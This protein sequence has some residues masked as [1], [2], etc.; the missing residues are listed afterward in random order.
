MSTRADLQGQIF[1]RLTVVYFARV[2]SG[3]AYWFCICRCGEKVEV[4]AC[5][6]K[7]GHTESCGCFHRDRVRETKTTH[8]HSNS[9][10]LR[11]VSPEYRSWQGLKT[12]CQPGKSN[13]KYWGDLG[14]QV[15]ERW[16]SSFENFLAD[17]GPC[18]GPGYS[19]DREN[20]DKGYEPGN[21]R[22]ATCKEQCDNRSPYRSWDSRKQAAKR[23]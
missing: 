3:N 13:S 17:M 1:G 16:A 10:G 15:C 2:K 9:G 18:P 19:I 11:D 6:L 22:W 21:C 12:R 14:V 5:H 8:G 23:T 20:G 4:S 7:A